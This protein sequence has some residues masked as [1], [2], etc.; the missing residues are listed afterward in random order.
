MTSINVGFLENKFIFNV[1]MWRHLHNTETQISVYTI[2][3]YL[4]SR[5]QVNIIEIQHIKLTHTA[6]TVFA[7]ITI[8][9][10]LTP[11]D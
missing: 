5:T 10:H 9:T 2:S 3:L 7:A 11:L 1:Q 4:H 8:H 6:N